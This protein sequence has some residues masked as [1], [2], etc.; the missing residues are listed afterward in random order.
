[1]LTIGD[2]TS[3]GD[4]VAFLITSLAALAT[5]VA[6]LVRQLRL[7]RLVRMEIASLRRALT[8]AQARIRYLESLLAGD[9][10][11]DQPPPS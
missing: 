8:T 6:S 9:R 7:A 1:M 10:D 3:M 11:G 2:A 5:A 4:Q